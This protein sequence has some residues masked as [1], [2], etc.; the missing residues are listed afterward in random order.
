VL[1]A[2]AAAGVGQVVCAS[3]GKAL[4]PYSPE[5]YSASKRA[6]EW[7]AAGVA[8]GGEMLCSAGRFTHVVDNSIIHQR[9]LEW[10]HDGII[11]LHSPDIAF[12][13]QSTREAVQLLLVACVG[14]QRGT[15]RV[16]AIIDLGWPVSLLDLAI[17][18]LTHTGSTAPIYIS[19][20]DP[21]Y[22][23]VPFPGLYDPATAGEASP[24]LN[25]VETAAAVPSPCPMADAFRLDMASE[26]RAVKLLDSLDDVCE[27]TQD[28]DVVRGVLD[29]LSWSLLD[30]T[31]Q[32]A[33]RQA[34]TR[35]AAIAQPHRHSMGTSHQRV[36]DVVHSA[37]SR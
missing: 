28:P 22:E 23:E 19:G 4:R 16:H 6:A 32:A 21:G 31:M 27:R 15:F 25:A 13:V 24:L 30:A 18:V 7:I 14:C 37:I 34:L 33:P 11:R 12:Y 17:G 29:E 9:L 2:A 26:P 10:A 1:T 20:Y 35:A 3:T 36:L 8:A 5:I